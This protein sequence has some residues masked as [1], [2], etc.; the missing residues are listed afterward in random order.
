MAHCRK[1]PAAHRPKAKRR[2]WIASLI[3]VRSSL[4][5]AKEYG[6]NME[7]KR[8]FEMVRNGLKWF[9]IVSLESHFLRGI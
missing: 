8:L 2:A 6:K 7:K 5:K 1:I 4:G 3:Q 9:E